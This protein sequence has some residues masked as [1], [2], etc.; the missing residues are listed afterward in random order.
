MK[1]M[2]SCLTVGLVATVLLM[3]TAS[4]MGAAKKPTKV[5]T[6]T[7]TTTAVTAAQVDAL[8]KQSDDAEKS[9]NLAIQA[10]MDSQTALTN[11][12]NLEQVA[13]MELAGAQQAEKKSTD[14][15][16]AA[17]KTAATAKTAADT[18]SKDVTAKSTALATANAALKTSTTAQAN[19]QKTYNTA[20]ASKKAAA[21]TA[22]DK[23]NADLTAK[24]TAANNAQKAYDD[25][26][27]ACNV[28]KAAQKAADADVVTKTTAET[29][30][31][32]NTQ[33]C[34]DKVAAAS[35]Q[36]TKAEQDVAAKQDAEKTALT[37][38]AAAKDAYTKAKDTYNTYATTS[39]TSGSTLTSGT[40]TTTTTTTILWNDDK[41]PAVQVND[42]TPPENITCSQNCTN[43][44][45][46]GGHYVLPNR[47][48]CIG[49]LST[50]P[51]K[52]VGN[53]I[54]LQQCCNFCTNSTTCSYFQHYIPPSPACSGCGVCFTWKP[55]QA[56]QCVK[57]QVLTPPRL[58]ANASTVGKPC[59]YTKHDP[60]F[61]G[62]HGTRFEFNGAPEK[63][64]CLITDRDLHVNMKMR[65][66][67]DTRTIGASLLRNGLAVRTWIREMGFV[68]RGADGV[69]HSFRLASRNGK[70][71]KRDNGFLALI[72]F[73]GRVLPALEPGESYQ[74]DGGLEF[75]FNG[76]ET[77]GGGFFDVD[78]YSLRI[79]TQLVMD[80]K[81]RPAHPLLQTPDDSQVHLN[82]N[83]RHIGR[84]PAIHG[85]MGQTYRAGRKERAIDY[86]MLSRLLHTPFSADGDNGKG[87]IDG[88]ASDYE[89]TSVLATD[90]GFSAFSASQ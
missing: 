52:C 88:K 35:T 39:T 15:K 19:A 8:K 6:K 12:Q 63:S 9:A 62:A 77:E 3:L 81:L 76:Y 54:S 71:D 80:V 85:I 48:R 66:Y 31:K 50:D 25:S 47:G 36:V 60:H 55:G 29:Q 49:V 14:D 67:Y 86:S 41:Y 79:G 90:C 11:A 10:R 42:C 16:V 21:K 65:G 44:S 7:V 70:S 84:S 72:E 56:P 2:H 17:Q 83:F 20:A 5:G 68:W 58:N 34:V 69:E 32:S 78:A 45:G 40:T 38:S 46:K 87:F 22:L 28:K 74:L 13:E 26:N 73:D 24:T 53:S 89:T 75:T 33:K 57:D 51:Y 82:V 37:T 61:R 27:N 30:A 1:R 4:A 59:P 64:Y 23:A 43:T 18:C